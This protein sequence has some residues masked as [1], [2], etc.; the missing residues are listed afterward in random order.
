MKRVLCLILCFVC[1]G[2]SAFY[3]VATVTQTDVDTT[4]SYD[5]NMDGYVDAVD[6]L[7]ILQYSVGKRELTT[8]QLLTADVSYAYYKTEDHKGIDG[9]DA[10]LILQYSGATG[11]FKCTFPS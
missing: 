3:A 4:C 2:S 5:I 7:W 9:K 11:P 8:E 1:L 10:L 6:A